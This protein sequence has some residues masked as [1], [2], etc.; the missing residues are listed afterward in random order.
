MSASP[1]D[2][3]LKIAALAGRR[4]ALWG[5]GREGRAAYHALRSRLPEQ[6][7]TLFCSVAEAA[8]AAGPVEIGKRVGGIEHQRDLPGPGEGF[9]LFDPA[10]LAPGM[11]ADDQAGFAVQPGGHVRR[12]EQVAVGIDVAKDGRAAFPLPGV[13]RGDEG[14]RRHQ[15]LAAGG[16]GAAE[17]AVDH[18]EADGG[19]ADG[20][21]VADAEEGLEPFLEPA[22]ERAVVGQPA[23]VEDLVERRVQF[24]AGAQVGAAD[25]EFFG[26]ERF[27]AETGQVT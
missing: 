15:R 8:D 10:G 7:L 13:G 23:V 3:P 21:D 19:V 14:E 25:V 27:S 6:A 20:D 12:R 18:L 22:Q 9:E 17:R 2:T 24:F 4:V 26:K 11:D 16:I 1:A 5:W